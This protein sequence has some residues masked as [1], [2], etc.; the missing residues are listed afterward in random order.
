LLFAALLGCGTSP[1]PQS[2]ATQ[3]SVKAPNESAALDAIKKINEAQSDYFK[4]NRRYALTFDELTEAHLLAGEPTTA[5][6]CPS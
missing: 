5:Q 4:K 2:P 3:P 6:T 1:P